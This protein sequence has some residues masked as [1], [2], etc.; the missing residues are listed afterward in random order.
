MNDD[1]RISDDDPISTEDYD[2]PR[3]CREYEDDLVCPC[4]GGEVKTLG[5]NYTEEEITPHCFQ[6]GWTGETEYD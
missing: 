5:G 4:C 1:P 3:P 2:Y 6:C